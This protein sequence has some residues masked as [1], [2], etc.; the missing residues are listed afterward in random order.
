MLYKG[1]Y[2]IAYVKG[3]T[4]KLCKTYASGNIYTDPSDLQYLNA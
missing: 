3:M 2:V 4:L 1:T